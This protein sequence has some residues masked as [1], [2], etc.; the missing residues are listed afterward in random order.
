MSAGKTRQ[1]QGSHHISFTEKIIKALAPRQII[2]ITED[3]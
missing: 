3:P 1:K 2:L